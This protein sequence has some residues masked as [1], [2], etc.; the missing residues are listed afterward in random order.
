[1]PA[2]APHRAAPSTLADVIGQIVEAFDAMGDATPIMVGRQY[3]ENFGVGSPPRVLFVPEP[4]GKVTSAIEMGC[5]CAIEHSCSVYVR[6]AESG[7]DLQ[8]FRNA[9][10]LADKVLAC[11]AVAASGRWAGGAYA[12]SSPDGDDGYG[13]EVTFSFTYK[14][15][16]RASAARWALPPA[17]AD[18][19]DAVQQPPSGYV[20][21]ASGPTTQG[22]VDDVV[23]ATEPIQGWEEDED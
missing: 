23:V 5:V 20:A 21:G 6:A 2:I 4:A 3:L 22:T 18:T 13:A 15:D 8:R 1:M 17:A 7:E 12:D 11:L 10:A 14:R 9:Y 19:S 16:V